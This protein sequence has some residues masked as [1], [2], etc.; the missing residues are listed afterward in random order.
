MA[1]SQ[2]NG[3]DVSWSLGGQVLPF[4]DS[5]SAGD[6]SWPYQTITL[7]GPDLTSPTEEADFA[8]ATQFIAGSIKYVQ[9]TP[10]LNAGRRQHR[11]SYR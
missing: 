9:F 2:P 6:D 3:N 8:G 5:Y 10:L 11:C 4:G 7:T 1:T